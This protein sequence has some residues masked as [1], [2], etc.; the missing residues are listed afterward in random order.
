M[1]ESGPFCE[2]NIGEEIGSIHYNWYSTS[3]LSWSIEIIFSTT[4]L[5][6]NSDIMPHY[7]TI[8][9]QQLRDPTLWLNCAGKN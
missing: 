1:V 4:F 9:P 3:L 5:L 8:M 7:Q 2:P 6:T